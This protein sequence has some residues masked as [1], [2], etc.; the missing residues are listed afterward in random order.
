[1]VYPLPENVGLTLDKDKG[2]QV[3][4]V[5]AASAAQRAG[6]RAGDVLE[7]INGYS[8]NSFADAQYALH[9]SPIKGQVPVSWLH[10]GKAMTANLELA[11]GWRKTNLTWRPSMLDLLPSLTLF[12]P[13]L[14]VKEKKALGLPEKHLAFRQARP[15]HSEARAM[16]VEEND[17]IIGID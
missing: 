17:I 3:R 14:D 6:I 4:T 15:V 13:D 8:I 11:E 1:W 16:G 5:R 12:G 7:Q 2:N 10:D 9:K